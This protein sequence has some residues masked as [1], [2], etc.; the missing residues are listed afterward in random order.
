MGFVLDHHVLGVCTFYHLRA[1]DVD[2]V[3]FLLSTSAV[4]N[5]VAPD[6]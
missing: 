4:S 2:A 3:L 6:L 5:V 1:A